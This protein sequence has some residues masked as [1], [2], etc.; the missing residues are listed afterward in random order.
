MSVLG[1][2]IP[3]LDRSTI[4]DILVNPTDLLLLEGLVSKRLIAH[5]ALHEFLIR[6]G[7]T[8]VLLDSAANWTLNAQAVKA[9]KNSADG[10]NRRAKEREN[11]FCVPITTR[12]MR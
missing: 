6:L 9:A 2:D 4:E 12:P 1:G 7:A 5:R 3:T 8:R 11:P 10:G